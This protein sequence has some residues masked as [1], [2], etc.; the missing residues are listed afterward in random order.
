MTTMTRLNIHLRLWLLDVVLLRL[1][2]L[3]V[4]LGTA[5][6]EYDNNDATEHPLTPVAAGCSTAEAVGA[7]AEVG[8]VDFVD[9]VDFV[10]C[11][12]CFVA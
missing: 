9:F 11:S 4:L 8:F 1:L 6:S 10:V 7:V 2:G 5:N 12:S 3:S